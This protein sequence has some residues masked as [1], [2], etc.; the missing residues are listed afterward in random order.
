MLR[1]LILNVVKHG[2]MLRATSSCGGKFCHTIDL[3]AT[4]LLQYYG[5][6]CYSIFLVLQFLIDGYSVSIGQLCMRPIFNLR[7][8]ASTSVK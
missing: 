6:F 4:I 7:P 8:G 2:F 5:M 3:T 1:M